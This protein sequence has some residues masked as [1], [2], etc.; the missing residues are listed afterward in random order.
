MTANVTVPY[1]DYSIPIETVGDRVAVY[2]ADGYLLISATD[3]LLLTGTDRLLIRGGSE[4]QSYRLDIYPPDYMV[5]VPE[6]DW[7]I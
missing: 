7:A 6:P 3:Y 2:A 4:M 5:P 1:P